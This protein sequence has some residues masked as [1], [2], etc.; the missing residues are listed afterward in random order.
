MTTLRLTQSEQRPELER[1]LVLI[2][3]F[4]PEDKL[5]LRRYLEQDW[6]EQFAALLD[7]VQSRVPDTISE[8]EVARDV[9][10]AIRAVRAGK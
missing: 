3:R 1:V 9:A 2:D 7:R 5:F 10:E 8:Q 6:A 4:S